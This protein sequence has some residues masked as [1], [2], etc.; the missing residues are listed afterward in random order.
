R[1]VSVARK[2]SSCSRNNAAPPRDA[3][4][5]RAI[6]MKIGMITDS[7]PGTDFDA[8]VETAARVAPRGARPRSENSENRDDHRQPAG[9]G[10]RRAGR[11][12][13]A[14]RARHARVRLRQLVVGAAPEARPDAGER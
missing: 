9:N 3:R 2:C 11:D 14:T 5:Q 4:D 10:F 7:L 8:L 1:A 12:G 6:T 13:G